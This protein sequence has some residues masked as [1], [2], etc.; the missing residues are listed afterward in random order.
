MSA[1]GQTV[2][3]DL[4]AKIL[5]LE[6]R[7]G[8]RIE[9]N[10]KADKEYEEKQKKIK[11]LEQEKSIKMKE[12]EDSK[13]SSILETP[14]I[15]LTPTNINQEGLSMSNNSYN[16]QQ[17]PNNNEYYQ[18]EL[19]LAKREM[20]MQYNQKA[21]EIEQKSREMDLQYQQRTREMDA[22][23]N[24]KTSELYKAQKEMEAYKGQLQEERSNLVRE[25]ENYKHSLNK[26]QSSDD[27]FNRLQES[28]SQQMDNK[29][30]Q[31]QNQISNSFNKTISQ[32]PKVS[33]PAPL[34][35]APVAP[36]QVTSQ[37][38]D[39]FDDIKELKERNQNLE[40]MISGFVQKSESDRLH[41]EIKTSAEVNKDEYP[42][43]YQQMLEGKFDID[44]LSNL[45]HAQR[46][47]NPGFTIEQG[48]STFENLYS[49]IGN[50]FIKAKGLGR[51]EQE[52]VS[53]GNNQKVLKS[54]EDVQ[55]IEQQ[56]VDNSV[57]DQT[58]LKNDSSTATPIAINN[59]SKVDALPEDASEDQIFQRS[60]QASGIVS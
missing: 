13:R 21:R 22:Q 5:E 47:A 42:V 50:H 43:V 15:Q 4:E 26:V 27:K 6:G 49:D 39:I 60:L 55:A 44:Q 58:T 52:L 18:R 29:I 30:N 37:N 19:D 45:I 31:M 2:I 14:R 36:T 24:Q 9:M 25:M 32:L 56:E 3:T 48:I 17:Q 11:E 1:G 28:M 38:L 16:N 51:G 59:R 33:A 10:A 41:K 34:P 8:R 53:I 54:K 7:Y 40:K 35:V 12:L 57:T 20:D 46:R 23:Y